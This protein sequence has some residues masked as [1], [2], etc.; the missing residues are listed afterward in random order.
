MDVQDTGQEG[1]VDY[2]E[3]DIEGF[4]NE[5]IKAYNSIAEPGQKLGDAFILEQTQ[6]TMRR[7]SCKLGCLEPRRSHQ[8]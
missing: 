8:S 2:G 4:T 6:D 1:F 3:F 7:F 5:E